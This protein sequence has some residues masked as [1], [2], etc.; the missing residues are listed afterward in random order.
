M[1][2]PDDENRDDSQNIDLFAF[3]TPDADGSP[4]ISYWFVSCLK[5]QIL[6]FCCIWFYLSSLPVPPP[7]HRLNFYLKFVRNDLKLL[8]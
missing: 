2:F 7:S 4:E 3:Q 5:Q 1:H 8:Q 6:E